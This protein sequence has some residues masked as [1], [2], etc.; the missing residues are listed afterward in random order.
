MYKKIIISLFLIFGVNSKSVFA[1]SVEDSLALVALYD[2]TNGDNWTN[3]TNWKTDSVS[4][5]YG[6]TVDTGR[7]ISLSLNINN[8]SGTIPSSIGNL[9]SLRTL[10]FASNQITGSIPPEIGNLSNLEYLILTSNQITGSIPPEIGNLSN[11][12][13]LYLTDNQITG[14]IPPEIGN[15]DNLERLILNDNQITGS[16]PPEIGD[17]SNLEHLFLNINQI[18]GPIPPEIG[19]LSNLL[20]LYLYDN[21]IT[22]SVPTEIGNLSN[23]L[24]LYLYNNQLTG[25]IP[26]EIGN[27]SNLRDLYLYDNELT[28]LPDLSSS[29]SLQ[30]LRVQN[31]KFTFE[32]IEPNIGFLDTS[33]IYS[34][35]DSVG[36]SKDTT[37][38]EGLNFT[39]SV[40]V[41]GEN[42]L[43]QWKKD[44][45]A[46]LG[47]TDSSYT[48]ISAEPGDAGSYICEI[49]NTLATELTLY[50]K[51]TNVTVIPPYI[52][53]TTPNG[54]EDW[55]AD[56]T[57][58][59][60]WIS[61]GT[62]GN[63]RIEY[64]TNNGFS[65]IQAA[66]STVD[67]GSYS[68]RIPD[69]PS[70]SCLVRVKNWSGNPSD[71]SNSVFSILSSSAALPAKLP[72]VYSLEVKGITADKTLEL[73][74]AFPEKAEFKLEVYDI[75]GTKVNEFSGESPAGFYSRRID[76]NGKSAGVY[77]L[78][79]EANNK[80]FAQI[81]KVL[82]VK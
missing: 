60:T 76:M 12:K 43:Y 22:G 28:D 36:K 20:S 75:K 55:R 68:W 1:V 25:T 74:Y 65:W 67:D 13:H 38:V 5:W 10:N 32:D 46:I 44:A 69:M 72:E 54:G 58:D 21:Q 64:S 66:G 82:L 49:T 4:T 47:A 56:S 30:R 61:V 62:T 19:N 40:S 50:S 80:K 3:H 8:L 51:P 70:D 24:M 35:Q 16:I 9:S 17:L 14:S 23:L 81:N 2:S 18:T 41:G 42:N 73:R 11:L 79:I 29:T 57:Y 7:V 34:P 31:N 77:F 63:V 78:R 71:I 26:S 37:I 6:V 33:F 52:T 59:I 45:V 15:L 48:I 53:V 27:L 39:M